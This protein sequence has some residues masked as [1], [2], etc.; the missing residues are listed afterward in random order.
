MTGEGGGASNEGHR[1]REGM[2]DER[3]DRME[4]GRGKIRNRRENGPG[5]GIRDEGICRRDEK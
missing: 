5:K 4:E 1:S 3:I 2:R